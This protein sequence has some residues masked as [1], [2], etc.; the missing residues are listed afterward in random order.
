[1]ETMVTVNG[2]HNPTLLV[3]GLS[4]SRV[5]CS[6]KKH[7]PFPLMLNRYI[8]KS[9]PEKNHSQQQKIEIVFNSRNIMWILN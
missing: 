9:I 8:A 2:S 3:F 7:Q 6:H 5:G 4:G 1:M